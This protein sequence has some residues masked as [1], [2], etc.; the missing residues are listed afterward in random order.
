MVYENSHKNYVGWPFVLGNCLLI[1][2]FDFDYRSL[3]NSRSIFEQG[4][5]YLR[6]T[7]AH[8]RKSSYSLNNLGSLVHCTYS[9][10]NNYSS[11]GNLAL[12]DD[13]PAPPV[14]KLYVYDSRSSRFFH[15]KLDC[16]PQKSTTKKN[17]IVNLLNFLFRQ[18]AVENIKE[19]LPER[20]Q[21]RLLTFRWPNLN[22]CLCMDSRGQLVLVPVECMAES[23][24]SSNNSCSMVQDDFIYIDSAGDFTVDDDDDA[25]PSKSNHNRRQQ[26]QQNI[27]NSEVV[28]VEEK[29]NFTSSGIARLNS[30]E[31]LRNN[32][33]NLLNDRK[34]PIEDKSRGAVNGKSLDEERDNKFCN[35]LLNRRLWPKKIDPVLEAIMASGIFV[36]T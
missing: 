32:Y 11:L 10:N 2:H 15:Y 28:I 23:F 18:S 8:S 22:R 12:F 35:G 5:F 21:D 20:R 14:L 13:R 34:V 30:A 4:D 25:F 17:S 36:Y 26:Q 6:L 16:Q 9:N 19:N 7:H 29:R 3:K 27:N 24:C 31:D 1:I 33:A